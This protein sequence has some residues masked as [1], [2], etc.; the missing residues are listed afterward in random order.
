[1]PPTPLNTG[2]KDGSDRVLD[3]DVWDDLLDLVDDDILEEDEQDSPSAHVHGSAAVQYDIADC[4]LVIAIDYGTAF[5][6][7][8]HVPLYEMVTAHVYQRRRLCFPSV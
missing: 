5:T 4:R 8:S 7:N 3:A 1:M 2:H 6:S